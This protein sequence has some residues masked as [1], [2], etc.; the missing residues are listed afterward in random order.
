MISGQEHPWFSGLFGDSEIATILAPKEELSRMLRIEA[1]WTRALGEVQG[2]DKAIDA[3]QKIEALSLSPDDLWEGTKRDGIPVPTLVSKIKEQ[4]T[5]E[6]SQWVHQG[7][8]SQDVMD[9]SFSLATVQIIP[10]LIERLAK[11]DLALDH[12]GNRVS[13]RSVVAYTRMRP[14]LSVGAEQ[15]IEIW[16]RPFAVLK[17]DLQRSLDRLSVIQW[18]GPVGQRD[19]LAAKKIA[20]IFAQN[21]GLQDPGQAWHTDRSAI[22][23]LAT[24]LSRLCNATGKIGEDIAFMAALGD[25]HLTL[26][27]GGKSSAMAHKSNPITAE[28]LVTLGRLCASYAGGLLQSGIH[29][30]F[31]SG[32]AWMLEAALMPRMFIAAGAATRLANEQLSNIVSVGRA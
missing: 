32:Q 16:R 27:S 20:P 25:E 8:T 6:H 2:V 7:L 30:N 1:A 26:N 12:L 11:L 24:T 22:S 21:L 3:A 31:R 4:L 14:A 5:K 18:G 23:E 28:A 17:E 10:I 9:T 15:Q 19:H 29:E 13:G